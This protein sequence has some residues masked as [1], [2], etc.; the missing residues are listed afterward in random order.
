MGGSRER[1]HSLLTFA[2][3]LLPKRDLLMQANTPFGVANMPTL[4]G[5]LGGYPANPG[6]H[7][8]QNL[9]SGDYVPSF[10]PP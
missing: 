7:T 6:R 3:K 1:E 8:W 4:K 2:N 9:D 10:L 5:W